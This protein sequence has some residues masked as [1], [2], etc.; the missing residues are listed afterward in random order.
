MKKI[1]ID[2]KN[3]LAFWIDGAKRRHK[4]VAVNGRTAYENAR[5][6]LNRYPQKKRRE[7]QKMMAQPTHRKKKRRR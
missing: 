2:A 1:F 7:L 4:Y 3:K 6:G 5:A